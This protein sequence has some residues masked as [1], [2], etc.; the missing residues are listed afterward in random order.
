MIKR[1]LLRAATAG[2]LL[3]Q[4]AGCQTPPPLP[5]EP[6]VPRPLSPSSAEFSPA[7]QA[8]MAA[9]NA[10]N[11][12]LYRGTGVVV[13]GQESGGGLPRGPAVQSVGGGVVLNFEGADLREV[14]R[15]ILGDI[16][17][18]TYTI[19]PAVGGTVTIRT[20]SGIPRDALP[21]TLETLLRMNGATMVKSGGIYMV[22]PQ[23]AAVRGNITP[24]LGNSSRALP[25]GFS[26]QIVP[27]RY[28]GVRE[29]L[30]LLEPFAKDAQAVRPDELRNLLILSG[31]ERE[32]RHLMDTIDMFDIDWMAGMS[33]GL[34]VL[35]NSDVKQVMTEVEK[36][37]GDRN[38]S[39]ITGILK[40]VPIERMNAL[41][42][43]TP[44]PAYLDEVK[45]WIDR[46]DRSS[47][48]GGGL[49]FYVYHLHNTRAERLAPLLQQ[50]FTGR[51]TQQA[52]SAAPTLAPGTPAGTI[53]NPPQF[54]AQPLVNVVPPATSAP[55]PVTPAAGAA[56]AA[57]QGTG[58]VR[59][60]QVVAD[61]DNNTLLF[62]ATP[63]EYAVIEAALKRL[64]T[65]QRQVVIDV[66][67]AQIQLTDQLDIGIEWL[68]KGGAPSGRGTGGLVSGTLINRPVASQLPSAGDTPA[69]SL[70]KGFTYIIN[71]S[72]FPGGIQAALHLLDTYG[73]TKIVAN[74]QVAALDNQKATIK[75]GERIPINQQ[76]IIGGT[77]NAVTTT[78]QY[79]D[80]GVLLQV[81]P[82]INAGGLV[83][84]EVQAEVSD[85]GTA[86]CT[87]CSP[88]INT[89][90]IQTYVAVQSGSTMVMGG[91]INEGK[92]NQS[93]GLPWLSRIPILG[94]L[95]GQ[96][97]LKN[98][99]TELV[100][101]FTP[102]V[103]ES[104]ADIGS[105]VNE[106]RRKMENLDAAVPLLKPF[107]GPVFPNT[108]VDPNLAPFTS[109]SA[110]PPSPPASAADPRAP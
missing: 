53:V 42:V 50:A 30:R 21:A 54:A 46:L 75:S 31:T 23:A 44:Q 99:R 16:L 60:L 69:A 74:P 18:E 72:N 59:N 80:T 107:F 81:T 87:D 33:A 91:L 94:G 6:P 61:K 66:T 52:S 68:F 36:I 63:A 71:N 3:L 32:L 47:D 102:R 34:F 2:A 58:I 104:Q 79:I 56:G 40:I 25:P 10:A 90:S 49:Q 62:V 41:L 100:F 95:F 35:Q 12:R 85:P 43:V 77:T 8:T 29:M 83:S 4:V 76:T 13:R 57:A 70:V 20:S 5:A 101:F 96:Q 86:A 38:T 22:V 37:V 14:V 106:L 51:I 27:L 17:N 11:S 78:A 9:T 105:V 98:N 89:R 7:M 39:P 88:P 26:V 67:I 19:D 28:V 48:A 24:Q 92:Q 97:K 64:D 109:P 15:N 65:P 1:M 73:N 55:A 45:K 84:L 110:F 93:E 103:V 108:P 82:H